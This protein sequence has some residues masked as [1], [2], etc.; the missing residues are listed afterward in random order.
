MCHQISIQLFSI[1][2]NNFNIMEL[3]IMDRDNIDILYYA[4]TGLTQAVTNTISFHFPTFLMTKF[5]S[6]KK[7]EWNRTNSILLHQN[8]H[9]IESMLSPTTNEKTERNESHSSL[10]KRILNPIQKKL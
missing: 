2:R 3:Q 8:T 9:L 1:H 4:S 5:K 6:Q 7:T 10:W